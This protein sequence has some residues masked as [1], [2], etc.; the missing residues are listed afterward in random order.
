MHRFALAGSTALPADFFDNPTSPGGAPP[1]WLVH[2]A[3]WG[4]SWNAVPARAARSAVVVESPAMRKA[5]AEQLA[6]IRANLSLNISELAQVLGVQRPTIYAWMG[7]DDVVLRRENRERLDRLEQVALFWESKTH[8]PVGGRIRDEDAEGNSVVALLAKDEHEHARQVLDSLRP[9]V[10]QPPQRRVP[11][12]R[13]SLEKQGLQS[14]ILRNGAS[15]ID[16]ARR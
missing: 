14:R 10:E 7:E 4:P 5:P 8:L 3:N 16:R 2:F 11:S 6:R 1:D 15:E 13:E 12:L 9:K